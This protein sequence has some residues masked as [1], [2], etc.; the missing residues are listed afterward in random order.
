[1]KTFVTSNLRPIRARAQRLMLVAASL[2]IASVAAQAQ[3]AS[4]D[5]TASASVVRSLQILASSGLNFGTLSPSATAGTV[6][7]D[8]T[9]ARSATGGVT[10]I[11][12]NTGGAS[13]VTLSGT[14]ALSYSVGLPASVSLTADGGASMNLSDLTTNLTGNAGAIDANGSGNFGIGGTL[15]VAAAQAVANYSG[16][17]QVTLSWN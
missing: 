4:G 7:I 15:A 1:M 17:F 6:V 3:S 13:S 11:S 8:A 9:G 12:T 5:I 10:L 2:T 14:P 16:T